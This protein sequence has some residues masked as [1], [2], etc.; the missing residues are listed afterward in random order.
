MLRL[1]VL[2]SSLS[3]AAA[4]DAQ[5]PELDPTPEGSQSTAP[6]VVEA[7]PA[8]GA[9]LR[10]TTT[11]DPRQATAAPSVAAPSARPPRL[12][13][14]VGGWRAFGGQTFF[15]LG[16]ALLTGLAALGADGDAMGPASLGVLVYTAG[17]AAL[18]G[19]LAR[20]KSWSLRLGDALAGVY[21]GASSGALVG[22][23]GTAALD[24]SGLGGRLG[25]GVGIG[26]LVGALVGSALF[27]RLGRARD[28]SFSRVGRGGRFTGLFWAYVVGAALLSLPAALATERGEVLTLGAALGSL[29]GMTH[30]A[31][32]PRTR[33]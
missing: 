1:F 12:P 4:V 31:V 15:L 7:L 13:S 5:L 10:A 25:R 30:V 14:P 32:A 33:F 23:L 9:P 16:G 22:G 17:G 26:A 6:P 8:P 24:A 29:A 11:I 3:L 2:L 28:G 18:F 19:S 27:S 20:R 21:P